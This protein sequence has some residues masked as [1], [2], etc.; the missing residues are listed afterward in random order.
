MRPELG[1]DVPLQA[2]C[3]VL[4]DP[5]FV[6]YCELLLAVTGI[7][8]VFSNGSGSIHGQLC[9][10]PDILIYIL[11]FFCFWCVLIQQFAVEIGDLEIE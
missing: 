2:I 5:D 7:V 3:V 4:G 8:A 6:A 11:Y 1:I 9:V 10:S